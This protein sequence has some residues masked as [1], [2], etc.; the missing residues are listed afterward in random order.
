ME[1]LNGLSHSRLGSRVGLELLAI[2]ILTPNILP[3]VA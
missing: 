2:S 1:R 3:E